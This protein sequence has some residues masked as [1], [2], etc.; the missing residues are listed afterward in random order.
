MIKAKFLVDWMLTLK[1]D[2]LK[3]DKCKETKIKQHLIYT[4]L[5]EVIAL[6]LSGLYQETLLFPF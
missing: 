2:E 1:Q 6:Q 4:K 5:C 3:K